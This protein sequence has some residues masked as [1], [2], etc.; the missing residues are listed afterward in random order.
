MSRLTGLRH[1][2]QPDTFGMGLHGE[3]QGETCGGDARGSA[4]SA[5][6]QENG[7]IFAAQGWDLC[8]SP[9]LSSILSQPSLFMRWDLPAQYSPV[10]APTT[11]GCVNYDSTC[12]VFCCTTSPCLCVLSVR[13]L[14]TSMQISDAIAHGKH[15]L[16]RGP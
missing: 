3:G 8:G 9:P 12:R 7:G 1:T 15:S 14:G 6:E 11:T 4:V 16:Q 5:T 2:P 10:M 13:D